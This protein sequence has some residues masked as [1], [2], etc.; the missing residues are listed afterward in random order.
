MVVGGAGRTGRR[1]AEQLA[2]GGHDVVVAS[3]HPQRSHSVEFRT[4]TLDLGNG[5]EQALDSFDGVAVPVEPPADSVGSDV[6]LNRGV[7]TLAH[8]AARAGTHVVVVS[9]IYVTR[10]HE[11]PGLT[12]IINARAAGEQALRASGAPYTIV[13]P[14]WLTDSPM[15]GVRL[16][17][18]DTGDGQVS[19]AAVAEAVVAALS[20]VEARGTTFE[21]YDD[22]FTRSIDWGAAFAG[23]AADES[24][25]TEVS[26]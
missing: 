16:E 26:R 8:A 12:G 20:S 13:R 14:G 11:H 10:A 1:V 23:L 6:V 19:R 25:R 9:Q 18:G 4:V 21:I 2:K 24:A 15:T 5:L 3:R 17:Q 7:A 22:P